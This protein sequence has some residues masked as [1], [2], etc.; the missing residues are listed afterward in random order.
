M[1]QCTAEVSC[2]GNDAD[3]LSQRAGKGEAPFPG[4]NFIT[5]SARLSKSSR[6]R[7]LAMTK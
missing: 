6:E 1:G 3:L 5:D 2:C 4:E 7:L